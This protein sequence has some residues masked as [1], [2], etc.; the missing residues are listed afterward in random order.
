MASAKREGIEMLL[1]KATIGDLENKERVRCINR[2]SFS[3]SVI[4][5]SPKHCWNSSS[6]SFFKEVLVKSKQKIHIDAKEVVS[7]RDS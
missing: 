7:N 5:A 6:P 3:K 4:A 1:Q 2:G